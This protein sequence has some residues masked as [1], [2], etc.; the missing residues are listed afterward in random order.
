MIT[1]NHIHN[2]SVLVLFYTGERKKRDSTLTKKARKVF[3][4][5]LDYS[6]Y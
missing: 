6:S 4:K 3:Y 5:P 2:K 1:V